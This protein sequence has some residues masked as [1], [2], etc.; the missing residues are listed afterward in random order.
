MVEDW[1]LTFRRAWRGSLEYSRKVDLRDPMTQ[2][3]ADS[4]VPLQTQILEAVNAFV[5]GRCEDY[6]WRHDWLRSGGRRRHVAMGM[7]VADHHHGHTGDVRAPLVH[8]AGAR[9]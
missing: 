1:V 8:L 7:I 4:A 6:G 5:S 2:G 3:L 9:S